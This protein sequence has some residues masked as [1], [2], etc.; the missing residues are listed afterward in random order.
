MQTEQVKNIIPLTEH[1]GM[2]LMETAPFCA[3]VFALLQAF[4]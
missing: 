1:I 4:I 2:Q 3:E